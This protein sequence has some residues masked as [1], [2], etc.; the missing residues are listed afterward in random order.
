MK[1][2]G[3]DQIYLYLEKELPSE[4][5]KKIEEHIATCLKCKNVLEE[6]SLLLQAADSLPLL[7]TPPDF[8]QQ[9]MERIP[10]VKVSLREWVTA[11]AVGSSSI[12]VTLFAY[13]IFTGQNLMSVLD[14]FSH[15][16]WNTIRNVALILVKLFKLAS[17]LI[18]IISQF[19]GYFFENFDRLTTL[20]SPEVQIIIITFSIILFTSLILGIRRKILIGEKS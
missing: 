2:L 4:E 13:F 6:R 16:L 20:I 10:P 7:Q 11:V 18:T 19:V 17:L 3:I 8:I 9:I 15:T 1:C 5:N 14:N 12:M